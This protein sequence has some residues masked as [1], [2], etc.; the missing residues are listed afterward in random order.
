MFMPF[1]LREVFERFHD[2]Y[3]QYLETLKI[4][5]DY[6]WDYAIASHMSAKKIPRKKVEQ[7]IEKLEKKK[8]RN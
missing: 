7:F 3:E 5:L 6:K 8:S 2:D 1:G 4:I